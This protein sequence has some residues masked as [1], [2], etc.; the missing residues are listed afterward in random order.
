MIL[1]DNMYS[2]RNDKDIVEELENESVKFVFW[3]L[4]KKMMSLYQL[5][6]K[7]RNKKCIV[8]VSGLP[9]FFSDKYPT[10][11][12]PNFKYLADYDERNWFDFKKYRA[13]QKKKE[14][15]RL[16]KLKRSDVYKVYSA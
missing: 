8:K 3:L 16:S 12:H 7:D 13:E 14:A 11:S 15:E 1:G 2:L 4:G 10:S 5:K 6:K 9:P